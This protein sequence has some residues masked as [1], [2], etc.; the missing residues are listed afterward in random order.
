M[1][2]GDAREL[3][4]LFDALQQAG[5]RQYK[6]QLRYVHELLENTPRFRS[7][8]DVLR[9]STSG[10]DADDWMREKVFGAKQ[11]CHEW[12]ASER[13][14]LRL[15]LRI[16]QVCALEDDCE[17]ASVGHIFTYEKSMDAWAQAFTKHVVYPLV[18][19]LQTRL[20]TESE[21]LHQ[22]ER[23]RRQV[24]W[25]E[26]ENLY[27]EFV[28]NTARGEAL[29]DRRVREFLFTEG[30]DYPFSQPASPGGKADIVTGLEG[31]DPL[32]C[33]VKLFDGDSYSV[34]YL[35]Q[36]VGQALR[37]A[38]DYGKPSA[39]LVVFNLSDERLHLPSDDSSDRIPP[40]LQLEGVTVFLVVVQAKPVPSASKDHRRHVREVQRE[41]LIPAR[42]DPL[43]TAPLSGS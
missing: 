39:Y 17:P 24:E 34:T 42:E 4:R 20:G 1:R 13:E 32:V 41:Q 18:D 33:E 2:T 27:R 23:M 40:R 43:G 30:V 29:Y 5:Y 3:K 35:R 12:P 11:M 21:V 8:F 9:A 6:V 38:H 15:L 16:M 22:L 10:F 19:Y 14:K 26:Q 31:D 36:G 7:I 37:Y 28:A 25:F